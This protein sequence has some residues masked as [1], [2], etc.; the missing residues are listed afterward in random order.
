M[1]MP[2]GAVRGTAPA[3]VG[4]GAVGVAKPAAV[5]VSAVNCSVVGVPARNGTLL[6]RTERAASI[7]AV[8]ALMRI[9]AVS[10]AIVTVMAGNCAA[11]DRTD[12]VSGGYSLSLSLGDRGLIGAAVMAMTAMVVG[13]GGYYKQRKRQDSR[14]ADCKQVFDG[15]H[16]KQPPKKES[17]L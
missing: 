3:L 5:P 7:V 14:Q 12:G 15:F 10:S 6:H 4:S 8:T 2:E 17:F 13:R 9:A 16:C 1:T 11:L